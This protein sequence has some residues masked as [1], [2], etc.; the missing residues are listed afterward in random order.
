MNRFLDK[1]MSLVGYRDDAEEYE[2][3]IEDD[4]SRDSTRGG[5]EPGPF[6]RGRL[7]S[8]PAR[9]EGKPLKVVVLKVS[10][11]D[12]VQNIADHLKGRRPVVVNMQEADFD[13]ARRMIDFMSG[14]VYAL[15]G[16]SQRVAD[17]IFVF[18]PENVEID[19]EQAAVLREPGL[20]F[21]ETRRSQ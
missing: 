2:E 11:Y 14:V 20:F 9:G 10:K 18:A 5:A 3:V 17:G 13:T 19:A 6:R 8:L 1:L 12:E 21:F 16:A 7:V 15:N 4:Y